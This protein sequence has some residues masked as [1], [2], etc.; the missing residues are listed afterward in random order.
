MDSDTSSDPEDHHFDIGEFPERIYA[1]HDATTDELAKRAEAGLKVLSDNWETLIPLISPHA[2]EE[3]A[4]LVPDLIAQYQRTM[5]TFKRLYDEYQLDYVLRSHFT[6]LA[7]T[8]M[9]STNMVNAA[10]PIAN[11]IAHTEG[12]DVLQVSEEYMQMLDRVEEARKRAFGGEEEDIDRDSIE[13][14]SQIYMEYLEMRER[15]FGQFREGNILAGNGNV[16]AEGDAT[17]TSNAP[18]FKKNFPHVSN[19]PA[20]PNVVCGVRVGGFIPPIDARDTSG[21]RNKSLT[22]TEQSFLSREVYRIAILL[23]LSPEFDPKLI[24]LGSTPVE[25]KSYTY[26]FTYLD[27]GTGEVTLM[28]QDILEHCNFQSKANLESVRNK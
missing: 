3:K 7:Q 14:Y 28:E 27:K 21:F 11:F 2:H 24:C 25:G 8:Y 1:D 10:I 18:A 17:S 19:A 16:S 20:L 12:L 13:E 6:H 23:M 22:R 26:V 4:H 9:T 5:D 15:E